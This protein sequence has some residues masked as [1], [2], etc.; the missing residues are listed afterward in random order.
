MKELTFLDKYFMAAIVSS[1]F[2]IGLIVVVW[3]DEWRN[4]LLKFK[5]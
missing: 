5:L 4:K 2:I 3:W 1:M